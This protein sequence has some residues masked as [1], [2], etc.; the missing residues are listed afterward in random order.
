MSDQRETI[1][2]LIH[3]TYKTLL[4]FLSIHSDGAL[5]HIWKCVHSETATAIK[6]NTCLSFFPT[7]ILCRASFC[8]M[9]FCIPSVWKCSSFSLAQNVSFCSNFKRLLHSIIPLE[10]NV[11]KRYKA[12][13]RQKQK[14]TLWVDDEN[15][16]KNIV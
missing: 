4:V 8:C 11:C 13:S 15:T 14:K 9:A 5:L 6:W 12:K 3:A 16:E 1:S 2:V 10:Q 7:L